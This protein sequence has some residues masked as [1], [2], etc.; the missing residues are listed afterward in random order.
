[1]PLKWMM[2][3]GVLISGNHHILVGDLLVGLW[4]SK[5]TMTITNINQQVLRNKPP[6]SVVNTFLCLS[7]VVLIGDGPL[8]AAFSS[9]KGSSCC[10]PQLILRRTSVFPSGLQPL[11]VCI[12]SYDHRSLTCPQTRICGSKHF[13][14]WLSS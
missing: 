10:Y 11:M 8:L 9:L 13:D 4:N 2:T 12:M 5:W 6:G 14:H 3:R 7:L 1:M